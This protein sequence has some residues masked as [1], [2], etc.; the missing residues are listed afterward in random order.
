MSHQIKQIF[1]R[2]AEVK[3][4]MVQQCSGMAEDA[5][6][7]I[8]ESLNAG[9]KFLLCGNGGSAGDAQHLAAEFMSCLDHKAHP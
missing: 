1:N 8:A 9:G 4:L 2:S 3:A 5:A 6:Q 7:M